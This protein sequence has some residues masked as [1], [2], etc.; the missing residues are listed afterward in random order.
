MQG[1]DTGLKGQLPKLAKYWRDRGKQ[2]NTLEDLLL[3][4]YSGFKIVCIP[5]ARIPPFLISQQYQKLYQAIK[6]ASDNAEKKRKSVDLLMTSDELDRYFEIALAHFSEKPDEPFNFLSSALTYNPI[7]PTFKDHV[8]NLLVYRTVNSPS[9]SE[10]TILQQTAP[11]VASCIFLDIFRQRYPY[12]GEQLIYE[13][14]WL[15]ISNF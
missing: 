12:R 4:Y 7:N 11:L 3:C 10:A 9:L 2:I 8:R 15:L 14:E 1:K 5:H 13:I 6:E